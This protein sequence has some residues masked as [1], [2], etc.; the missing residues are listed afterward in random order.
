MEGKPREYV[1]MDK[2]EK[3]FPSAKLKTG[4]QNSKGRTKMWIVDLAAWSHC[5]TTPTSSVQPSLA[6]GWTVWRGLRPI[7]CSISTEGKSCALSTDK[8]D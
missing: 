6:Q 7:H 5:D 3:C 8:G 2:R 1:V 4:E